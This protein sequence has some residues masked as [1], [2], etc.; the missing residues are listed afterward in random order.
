[1]EGARPVKEGAGF[2]P[3]KT[4]EFTTKTSTKLLLEFA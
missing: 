4:R 2:V 1:M 3:R